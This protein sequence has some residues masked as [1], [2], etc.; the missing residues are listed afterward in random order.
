[1]MQYIQF[2]QNHY[3]L[4]HPNHPNHPNRWSSHK[5]AK[6]PDGW[7]PATTWLPVYNH[8]TRY[9]ENEVVQ[10]INDI[11][12]N[13]VKL[14]DIE[15]SKIIRPPGGGHNLNEGL[16]DELN[17][18]ES[19]RSLIRHLPS[20][21]SSAP[22]KLIGWSQLYAVTD[23]DDLRLS[24]EVPPTLRESES[25]VM[26]NALPQ[27]VKLSSGQPRN[28]SLERRRRRRRKF[29]D[30]RCVVLHAIQ[31]FRWLLL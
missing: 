5:T 16:L 11:V 28:C 30:K 13:Y 12:R 4:T 20:Y 8:R 17:L 21:E 22:V 24:R 7:G 31:V 27:D 19:A 6:I 2:H 9:D 26:G 3:S 29:C 23:K 10:L 18:T 1:M 14:S 15:E 25:G